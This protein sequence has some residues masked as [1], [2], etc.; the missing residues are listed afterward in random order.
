[1]KSILFID[2]DSELARGVKS[3][4][5][6]LHI[7][8]ELAARKNEVRRLVATGNIGM[9]LAN[10]EITTIRLEDMATELDTI[11]KRNRIPE[12]PSYYICDDVPVSGENLPGDVPS[13]YLINRSTGLDR[14]YTIIE[15]TLLTDSAIEQSGGFVLYSLIHKEFIDSYQDILKNLTKISDKILNS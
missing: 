9:I 14:I 1:M 15:N 2:R 11:V 12:F 5:E 4:A 6:V 13:S 7:P 8:F 3:L 10:T